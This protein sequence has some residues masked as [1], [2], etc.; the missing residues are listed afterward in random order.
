MRDIHQSQGVWQGQAL[1]LKTRR[2][3]VW[4]EQ[5]EGWKLAAIQFSSQPED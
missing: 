1:T 3:Q 5:P 4:V 2:S